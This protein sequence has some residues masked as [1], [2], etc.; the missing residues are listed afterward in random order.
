MPDA[1]AKT[2]R[3]AE[4]N[5][6]AFLFFNEIGIIHQLASAELERRLPDGLRLPHFT[7][8]NHLSR[9]GD[10]KRPLDIAR[11]LQVSKA[12][13]TNTLSR[14]EGPGLIAIR[15]D[16]ADGRGKRVYLTEAGRRLRE[17]AI[18]SLGPSLAALA[19]AVPPGEL[20][21]ALPLLQKV[22][23]YLDA[24]RD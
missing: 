10:A 9:M 5:G 2:E 19:E 12:A 14:L 21:A 17:D 15:P 4:G 18:A 11:A 8:L 6:L 22:R 20:A 1:S 3:H 23:R 16:P 24:A 13:I 7:V